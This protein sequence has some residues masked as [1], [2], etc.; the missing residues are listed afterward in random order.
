MSNELVTRN[1]AYIQEQASPAHLIEL[2]INSQATPETLARLLDLQERWESNQAKKAYVRDMADFKKEAPAV[3]IKGDCVDFQSAKGRTSYKY[4]NLGSIVQEITHILSK[5]NFSASWETQQDGKSI[6]VTCHVTHAH[7]HRESVALCAQPDESGNKNSIQAVGSTVTYLQRYTLLSALGLATAEDDNDASPQSSSRKPTVQPPKEKS[8]EIKEA[9][10]G[11]KTITQ[12]KGKKTD[13]T[14]YTKFTIT[15]DDG[16]A[17][18]TFSST[19]AETA[20]IGKN[21]NLRIKVRYKENQYGKTIEEKGVD[22][23]EEETLETFAAEA[24]VA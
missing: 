21:S 5:Y 4:A 14:D 3:I 11:V 1:D 17:Y 9:I 24:G 15:A 23:T 19:D 20:K 6:G 10:F 7:G 22:L 8:L 16:I 13:G 2:A 18:G 12:K